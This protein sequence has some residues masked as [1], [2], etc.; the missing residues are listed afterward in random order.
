MALGLEVEQVA[1]A[2]ITR[3]LSR[4][5]EPPKIITY[6]VARISKSDGAPRVDL[7]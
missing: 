6:V 3:A 7:P 5:G 1:V 2:Q 4:R